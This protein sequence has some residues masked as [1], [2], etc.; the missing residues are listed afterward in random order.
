MAVLLE[1]NDLAGLSELPSLSE[2]IIPPPLDLILGVFKRHFTKSLFLIEHSFMALLNPDNFKI[3]PPLEKWNDLRCNNTMI[4][5]YYPQ[6]LLHT[7][8]KSHF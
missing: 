1:N 5:P 2:V 3:F 4:L 7:S 8:K 6:Q